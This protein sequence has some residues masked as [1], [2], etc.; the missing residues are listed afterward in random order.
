MS[1]VSP[2]TASTST[3]PSRPSPIVYSPPSLTRYAFPCACQRDDVIGDLARRAIGIDHNDARDAPHPLAL[4][5]RVPAGA[6]DERGDR[7]LTG[8]RRHL[9]QPER[10][11]RRGRDRPLERAPHLLLHARVEHRP[12]PLLDAALELVLRHVEPDDVRRVACLLR[13]QPVLV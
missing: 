2:S 13:P 9:I 7:L 5:R 11:P 8:E 10:L 4:I 3:A 6:H 1:M 12:R